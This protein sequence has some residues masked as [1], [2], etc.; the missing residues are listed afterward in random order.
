MTQQLSSSYVTQNPLGTKPSCSH[1][2]ATALLAA[3]QFVLALTHP[4]PYSTTA[5]CLQFCRHQSGSLLGLVSSLP[6]LPGRMDPEEL[7]S[8]LKTMDR[9]YFSPCLPLHFPHPCSCSASALWNSFHPQSLQLN[10]F[11]LSGLQLK[12][13]FVSFGF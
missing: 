6:P 12:A 11:F 4:V 3:E 7:W 9:R 10:H 2:W 13:P 1:C 5:L 8:W